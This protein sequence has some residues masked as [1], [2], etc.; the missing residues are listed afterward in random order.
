MLRRFWYT[1]CLFFA[2]FCPVK[3]QQLPIFTQYRE[4]AAFINPAAISSDF[5]TLQHRFSASA[6]YR[7]QWEALEGSPQ[8]Q[9]LQANTLLEGGQS[10]ALLLGGTLLRD[11]TG[12]ISALGAYGRVG[13]LIG[14][15]VEDGGVSLG[16]SLGVVQYRLDASKIRLRDN[17]D[18]LPFDN[19]SKIIP[20]IGAGV[21][22][23]RNI[24][25]DNLYYVGLSVPQLAALSWSITDK[26]AY[27][28]VPHAFAN[29]GWYRFFEEGRF[30]ETS[31]FLKYSR[32]A[33]L[34]VD[35]N[36]RYQMVANFWV[37]M[38][39]NSARKVHF[40]TGFLLGERKAADYR[41]KIGY[42]F[43]YSFSPYAGYLGAAH[44][45]NI[46][47]SR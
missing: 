23:Y 8:T 45:F 11:Q 25:N 38:G 47:F 35:L 27:K 40:E 26:I 43:D 9:L 29:V 13:G 21:F 5:F 19:Q 34:N 17:N 3:A 28:R 41:I 4:Y 10:N 24:D 39:A 22:A 31:S 46:S 14:G 30:L 44:E 6:S 18:V 42:G 32:N 20:D 36:L 12:P 33:A 37:G 7:L 1:I 2:V 16:L 15:N